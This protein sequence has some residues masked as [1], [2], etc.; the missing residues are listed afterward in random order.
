MEAHAKSA[1]LPLPPAGWYDDPD[2]SG[3]ERWWSGVGWTE[4]ARPAAAEPA[5]PVAA[6][7]APAV[8]TAS[9]P[10]VVAAA[11]A[12]PR[13]KAQWGV[14]SIVSIVLTVIAFGLLALALSPAWL[15]LP[16][17]I[18]AIL[19]FA[20]DRR[21]S[22]RALDARPADPVTHARIIEHVAV[23]SRAAGIPVP[24]VY[25]SP[26]PVRNAFALTDRHGGLVCVMRGTI[27][28]L[29]D[30][31]LAAVLAHEVGHLKNRDSLY[32]TLFE[33][34]RVSLTVVFVVIALIVAL[35][36]SILT[37]GRGGLAALFAGGF[38]LV[39]S[40]AAFLL[41]SAGM[42]SREYGADAFAATIHPDPL[43]LGRALQ[44]L[45]EPGER[46]Q[47]GDVPVAVAARCIVPPFA[48][49]FVSELV[50]SHPTVAKRIARIE[51][52][53]GATRVA[54][55]GQT[56]AAAK[57]DAATRAHRE[58]VEFARTAATVP[59]TGSEPF[60]PLAGEQL[61]TSVPAKL[62]SPKTVDGQHGFTVGEGGRVFVTTARAIF[63]G[64]TGR[65]E[66]HWERLHDSSW[67]DGSE[68][69][70]MLV[71]AVADRRRNSGVLVDG[72]DA[73]ELRRTVD[74]AI[75][76]SRG[77]RSTLIARLEGEAR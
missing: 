5:H 45:Q 31:E 74:L 62:V 6:A 63:V 2:S 1:P 3:L 11:A 38:V 15:L 68:G 29:P 25:V 42:R 46:W 55:L 37:R 48:S 10:P 9:P 33:S 66:W 16:V 47:I 30:D 53:V 57:S 20:V 17:G 60:L 44:R 24:A 41:I 69:R 35:M 27:E 7:H 75:A 51:K 50:A 58:A 77:Q 8:P 59:F 73:E 22:L 40:A 28:A 4:H 13:I 39:G 49:G 14:G 18:F 76:E 70:R 36:V 72:T 61:W 52:R 65:V 23:A 19:W 34:L 56:R 32:A 64:L 21:R 54:A 71:L 26:Q 12:L 43:A 67:V